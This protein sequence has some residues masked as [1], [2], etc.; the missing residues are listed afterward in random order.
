MMKKL[1]KTQ[2]DQFFHKQYDIHDVICFLRKRNYLKIF[3]FFFLFLSFFSI[4]LF[5][6]FLYQH[7]VQYWF[8]FFWIILITFI[9]YFSRHKKM[10]FSFFYCLFWLFFVIQYFYISIMKKPFS[11]GEIF[12]AK[13]GFS[14]F[15]MI[16]SMI[17]F[18]F[19]VCLL[20]VVIIGLL[21]LFLLGKNKKE[22]RNRTFV[23]IIWLVLILILLFVIRRH[24]IIALG[25]WKTKTDRFYENTNARNVYEEFYNREIAFEITGLYEYSMRDIYL[26]FKNMISSNRKKERQEI[27]QYFLDHP[28]GNSNTYTGLFKNK[29]LIIIMAES[30]DSFLITKDIMPTVWKMKESSIDFTNRYAP[31]YGGG[32]TLNTEYC[33]NTGRYIPI[34]YNIYQYVNNHYNYSLASMFSKQGYETNYLHFNSGTFYNR[35]HMISSYGYQNAYFIKDLYHKTYY[36]DAQ[37]MKNKNIYQLMVSKQKPFLTFFLTY[38][39][40]LPYDS[41]NVLCNSINNEEDCIKKLAGYTDQAISILLQNLRKDHLLEDTV[42]VFVTDHY[43]YGYDKDKLLKIKGQKDK[44]NLDRVPFFIWNN[45]KY[46]QKV[47]IYMDTQD[48]LPTLFNLFGLSYDNQYIGTDVFSD[49]N[50]QYVYF[51][52]ASYIS[53]HSVS[54]KEI[55]QKIS[56]NQWLIHT[57]YTK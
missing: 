30:I 41:S 46:N 5:S 36:N 7:S 26:Y 34:N 18:K 48:I 50:D 35:N 55:K 49:Q 53:S 8:S 12:Y 9:I 29:N 54:S 28:K 3:S 37:L 4:Q 45:D 20:G 24:A 44:K 22:K 15:P 32:K 47:G 38:S 23:S 33:L 16:V 51:S 2:I 42:I 56:M 21:N 27:N 1:T 25:P 19:I 43:A 17:D 13:E 52:D 57:D 39:A 14:Y 11:I 6:S 40:H 10:W 31:S